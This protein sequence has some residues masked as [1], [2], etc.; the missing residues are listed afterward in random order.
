MEQ[1]LHRCNRC[2]TTFTRKSSLLRHERAG[3]KR[4]RNERVKTDNDTIADHNR[5]TLSMSGSGKGEREKYDDCRFNSTY[6]RT[7]PVVSKVNGEFIVERDGKV[8]SLVD[9]IMNG[10]KNKEPITKKRKLSVDTAVPSSS[11]ESIEKPTLFTRHKPGFVFEDVEKPMFIAA[12][13]D[14]DEESIADTIGIDGLP[15]PPS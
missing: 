11:K 8:Q 13:D 2:G 7:I 14:D 15:P 12:D 10:G 9:E 3:C 1:R 6:H 4:G 5:E